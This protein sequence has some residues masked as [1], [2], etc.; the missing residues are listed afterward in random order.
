VGAVVAHATAGIDKQEASVLE[1]I[2][3]AAGL[4]KPE[5]AAIVKRARG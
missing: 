1:K 3:T 2:A 5:I 4:G